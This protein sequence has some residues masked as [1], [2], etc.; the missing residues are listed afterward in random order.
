MK[1]SHFFLFIQI[2]FLSSTEAGLSRRDLFRSGG[3]C[4]WYAATGNATR[5]MEIALPRNEKYPGLGL[6]VMG[7]GIREFFKNNSSFDGAREQWTFQREVWRSFENGALVSQ[8]E[9]PFHWEGRKYFLSAILSYRGRDGIFNVG[10]RVTVRSETD[11]DPISWLV[12]REQ[13]ENAMQAGMDS[14]LSRIPPT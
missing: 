11:L 10:N 9:Y 3:A 4:L 7:E 12:L 2:A 14:L 8:P 5:E 13:V 1:F 6:Q